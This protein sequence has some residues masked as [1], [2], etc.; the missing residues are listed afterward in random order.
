MLLEENF[1]V[2]M[3]RSVWAFLY[4]ITLKKKK[5]LFTATLI[6]GVSMKTLWEVCYS[7]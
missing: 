3:K 1:Y 2:A 6:I 5:K 7:S 4:N